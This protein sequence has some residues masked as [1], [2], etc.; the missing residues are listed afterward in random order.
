MDGVNVI[1]AAIIGLVYLAFI[2]FI[3]LGGGYITNILFSS[4][5]D[6]ACVGLDTD[7]KNIAK[8][9]IVMF[10]MVFIPICIAPFVYYGYNL[11]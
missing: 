3:L 9:S 10:W 8:M 6:T 7:K 4:S 11:L 5:Y 1:I 2:I